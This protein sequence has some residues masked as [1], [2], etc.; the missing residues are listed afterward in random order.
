MIQVRNDQSLERGSGNRNG[1][2][3]PGHEWS[4]R[5]TTGLLGYPGRAVRVRANS[6][7]SDFDPRSD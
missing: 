3:G 1:A 6:A 4:G 2:E 7:V 5:V